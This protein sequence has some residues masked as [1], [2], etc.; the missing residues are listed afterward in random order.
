MSRRRCAQLRARQRREIAAFEKYLARGRLDQSQDEPAERGFSRA[1]FAHQPQRFAC[2][3]FQVD[4]GDRFDGELAAAEHARRSG[5]E[6]LRDVS[7]C[8]PAR[9]TPRWR[10]SERR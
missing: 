6:F 2:D 1:R 4:A 10:R 5:R 7:R 9:S 8:E 3:D